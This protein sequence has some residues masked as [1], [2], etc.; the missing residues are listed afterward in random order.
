MKRKLGPHR[1]FST[2]FMWRSVCFCFSGTHHR[3][4]IPAATEA[5]VKRADHLHEVRSVGVAQVSDVSVRAEVSYYS[6]RGR[7]FLHVR[8]LRL[9]NVRA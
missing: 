8:Q 4:Y 3:R 1:R 6:I 5:V 9:H 7:K 2:F